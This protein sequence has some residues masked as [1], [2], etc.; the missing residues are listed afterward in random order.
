MTVIFPPD[1]ELS[2]PAPTPSGT[3]APTG[4][5][6]NSLITISRPAP[7]TGHTRVGVIDDALS[8]ISLVSS[9]HWGSAA[10]PA[11]NNWRH[12]ANYACRWQLARMP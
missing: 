6:G 8:R 10:V 2:K 5:G 9:A 1:Y 7:Q 3:S 12:K 11:P 4:I